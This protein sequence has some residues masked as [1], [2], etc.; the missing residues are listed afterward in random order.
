[1]GDIAATQ[2]ATAPPGKAVPAGGK[3]EPRLGV[4][5]EANP[6]AGVIGPGAERAF[7]AVLAAMQA[8]AAPPLAGVVPPALPTDP[9]AEP[10][11][12]PPS[13]GAALPAAFTAVPVALPQVAPAAHGTPAPGAPP[14]RAAPGGAPTPA[15]VLRGGED[16]ATPVTTAAASPAAP[17]QGLPARLPGA[18]ELRTP[19]PPP[20]AMP[21]VIPA[22][23]PSPAPGNVAPLPPA[24]ASLPGAAGASIAVAPAGVPMQ[25]VD[26]PLRAPPAPLQ[27][28]IEAP[29][30]G[31]R[32]A[33]ELGERV[34][35]I[36][37][38]QGQ[39]A[40]IA[41]NPPQL[42]PLEVRLALTGSEAAAQFYSPHPAV[43]EAIEAALP[44]LRE[45]LAESGLTLGE[46]QVRDQSLSR[47]AAQH[48]SAGER[49]AG[50]QAADPAWQA[51]AV[52]AARI[53]SGGGRID[54]YI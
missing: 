36:S 14:A 50:E 5:A 7:L 53:V 33:Q 11:Q 32:F 21:V 12:A 48:P 37:G 28:A 10:G 49:G 9:R 42:G 26:A 45:M 27:L 15:P 31:A 24:V 34:L 22:T 40:E 43:R 1:M 19:P 54:V 6:A 20:A 13:P 4:A 18:L 46:A 52:A 51:G 8:Q 17:G 41:L 39:L 44:R 38:R 29:L 47:H 30:P 25:P 16:A 35:W 2:W 3:A 23:E